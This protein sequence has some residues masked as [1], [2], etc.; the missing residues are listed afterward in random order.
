MNFQIFYVS[1]ANVFSD[2]AYLNH[3]C[4]MCDSFSKKKTT[5][6]IVPWGTSEIHK[7][8]RSSFLFTS[9]NSFKVKFFFHRF[10]KFNFLNR[11]IFGIRTAL[12]LRKF[13][14]N[15]L[16]VTRSLIS[17]IFMSIFQIKHFLEIHHELKGMTKILM[18]NFNFIKSKYL[19]KLIFISKRLKEKF[20]NYIILGKDLV[21]HDAVDLKNY[22]YSFLKKNN[23][24]INILYIGSFYNGRGVELIFN[25]AKRNPKLN[26]SLIGL[27]NEKKFEKRSK[28][29]R[30]FKYIDYKKV[31]KAISK[32][33]ILLMPYSSNTSINARGIN[34][35]DYCSP[36][37]MF[38]YLAAG[39][40]ILSSK[41]HGICEVLKNNNNAVIVN[42]YSLY[43][44]NKK[45]NF[46]IQNIDLQKKIEFNSLLTAKKNTWNSRAERFISEF[47]KIN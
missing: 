9:K 17:S 11:L 26:F 20:S 38:D 30:V 2:S 40:I 41:L 14:C 36:I 31:P 32:A 46:I 1:E 25:L 4:K 24:K 6:L 27:R 21:L 37:K 43:E 33:D 34:T 18:L 22:K 15:K 23:H 12:Y 19:I 16:I 45:I 39:K 7:T 8:L 28:N 10:T 13:N 5:T 35:A 47:I 42:N 29:L 3:T 44:W